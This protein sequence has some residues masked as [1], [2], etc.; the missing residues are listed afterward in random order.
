MSV[1]VC[2]Q[3][4]QPQNLTKN[5]WMPGG[6]HI[7]D[8][9]WNFSFNFFIDFFH[10]LRHFFFQVSKKKSDFYIL[11]SNLY[12]LFNSFFVFLQ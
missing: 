8:N 1:Y 7:K 6:M 12:P 3:R 10:I 2:M 5:T 11:S 9:F 4:E